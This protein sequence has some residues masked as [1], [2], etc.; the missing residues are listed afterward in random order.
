MTCLGKHSPKQTAN[1]GYY[2]NFKMSNKR[3][4][5]NG[6]GCSLLLNSYFGKSK[7]HIPGNVKSTTSFESKKING[8]IFKQ[9]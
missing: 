9:F 4:V 6:F 5:A 3:L 7:L 8:G 1:N 2:Y